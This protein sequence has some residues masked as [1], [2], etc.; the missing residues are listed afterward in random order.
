MPKLLNTFVKGVMNKDLDLSL[1]TQDTFIHAENL[2]FTVN[3]GN[4]G[5]GNNLKG[6][7]QVSNSTEGNTDLKC[8]SAYFDKNTD[9]IFYF[10]ASTSGQ[11]SKI[12][13]YNVS[14]GTTIDILHDDQKI[15][16][17][18]KNGYITGV[19]EING[20][21]LFSEWG[22]NPRRVNI[23]RAKAYGKNNFTEEEI[24]LMI[25]PPAQK[26]KIT[27]RDSNTPIQKEN[28]IEERMFAFSYRYRYLDG[29]YSS[30]APFTNFAF[31]PKRFN[32]DFSTQSNKSMINR[33][34]QVVLEFNTGSKLVTEIQLIFKQSDT[35]QGYI[36][37]DFDKK[38]LNWG[39]NEQQTFVFDNLKSTRGLPKEVLRNNEE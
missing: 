19:D 32:Y 39:D 3:D 13:E 20:L 6:T 10:L 27:L 38:L 36:I 7:I 30:V 9:S 11:V 1:I 25:K 5:T 23:E 22:N 37:D 16:N 35:L 8:I 12:V 14:T 31:A 26:L 15:L 4:D 18:N 29:E 28:N 24:A 34:N 21:L 2:R 17:L 33:F